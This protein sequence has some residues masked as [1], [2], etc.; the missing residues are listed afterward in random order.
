[1]FRVGYCLRNEHKLCSFILKV[2]A[3]DAINDKERRAII[4]ALFLEIEDHLDET[5]SG[6]VAELNRC[7]CRQT[8]LIHKVR[9]PACDESLPG[10]PKFQVTGAR[11]NALTNAQSTSFAPAVLGR[12][13]F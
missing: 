11:Q 7:S 13:L 9:L 8:I 2:A 5:I 1:M 4:D 6:N 10:L 12:R 3:E